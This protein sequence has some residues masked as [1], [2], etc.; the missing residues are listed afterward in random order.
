MAFSP[1]KFFFFLNLTY[2]KSLN[3][4]FE[5]NVFLKLGLFIAI[6]S[7]PQCFALHLTKDNQKLCS[8][9]FCNNFNKSKF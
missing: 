6:V 9:V 4:K 5:Y 2:L 3:P 7:L 1:K 8:G